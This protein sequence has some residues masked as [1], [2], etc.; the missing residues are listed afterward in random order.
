MWILELWQ[1]MF[2]SA[3]VGR[4]DG[5][6]TTFEAGF[7][8]YTDA[9][10][11]ASNE[12]LQDPVWGSKAYL[13]VERALIRLAAVSSQNRALIMEVAGRD[14]FKMPAHE[15]LF[16][17]LLDVGGDDAVRPAELVDCV[18]PELKA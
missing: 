6:K 7:A 17:L 4:A 1:W 11:S 2:R 16:C 12:V 10:P 9:I 18:D 13:E 15:R 3:H 8:V 14:C 5:G